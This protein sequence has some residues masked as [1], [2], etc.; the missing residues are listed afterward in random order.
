MRR[1]L[2]SKKSK[3]GPN[4]TALRIGR[5]GVDKLGAVGALNKIYEM[6]VKIVRK[7]P[8]KFGHEGTFRHDREGDWENTEDLPLK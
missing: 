1:D 6:E 8:L 4:P 2:V 7:T 3:W 5:G